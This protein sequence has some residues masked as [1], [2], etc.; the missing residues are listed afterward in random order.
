MKLYTVF[1]CKLVSVYLQKQ[2]SQSTVIDQ[3]YVEQT[4]THQRPLIGLYI[5]TGW[6]TNTEE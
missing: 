4:F 1:Y 6:T 2:T 5:Y 3:L